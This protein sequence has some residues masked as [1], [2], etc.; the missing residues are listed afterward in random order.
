M[1]SLTCGSGSSL[2]QQGWPYN[3]DGR[4]GGS[5]PARLIQ[6]VSPSYAAPTAPAAPIAIAQFHVQVPAEAK[7]WFDGQPTVQTGAA[8]E[9]VSSPLAQGVECTYVVR[10]A[11]RH[12]DRLIEQNRSIT[13][14]TG[15]H[16]NLD[17]TGSAVTASR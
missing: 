9:F 12:G 3:P 5:S 7:I 11:W 6:G 15:D 4:R 17:F 10:V 1:M 2:A 13:F 8:R 14:K 16:L